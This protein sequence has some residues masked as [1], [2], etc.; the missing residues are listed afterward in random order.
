MVE[1]EE[2]IEDF[3]AIALTDGEAEA[4]FGLAEFVVKAR[5]IVGLNALGYGLTNHVEIP[6]D[7][8]EPE[9]SY[10]FLEFF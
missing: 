4:L 3:A 9:C 6:I 10:F 5:M 2:A 8:V 7:V 1:G